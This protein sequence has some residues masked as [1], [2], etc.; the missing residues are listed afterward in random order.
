MTSHLQTHDAVALAKQFDAA[1]LG[2]ILS[3]AAISR[4]ALLAVA[5]RE[6]ACAIPGHIRR[7]RIYIEDA[8]QYAALVSAIATI[9][10]AQN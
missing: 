1:T 9:L 2:A 5:K 3:Q 8:N 10:F 6:A 7:A 4:D